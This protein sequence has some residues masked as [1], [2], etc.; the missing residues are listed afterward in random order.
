MSKQESAVDAPCIRVSKIFPTA[1]AQWAV[2]LVIMALLVV[3]VRAFSVPNP[4]MILVSGLVMCAALFG[5]SGGVTAGA[6][7][8]GY[9]LY[10]FSKSNSWVTFDS[11]GMQKVVVSAIGIVTVVFFVCNL[12]RSQ[13]N[14]VFQLSELTNTLREDNEQLS[15]HSVTDALTG[16]RN[17]LALQR[18]YDAYTSARTPHIVAMLDVDSFKQVNDGHG[19][20]IGDR[21]LTIMAQSLA[22]IYGYDHVYRYG[23][24]E[25]TVIVPHMDAQAFEAAFAKA[26]DSMR[27]IKLDGTVFPTSISAGYV[28][29]TPV[30]H[31]DLRMMLKQADVML[32]EAKGAGKARAMGTSFPVMP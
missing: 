18:D 13:K 16:I 4:N 32:Y 22:E 15:A 27:T 1:L 11:E 26:C 2:S 12:H 21:I 29:G 31:D 23:G 3:V 20:D 19:H 28:L 24:D 9:T 17:R 8:M 30:H 5:F 25:F 14:A 7:M 10:F 6:V